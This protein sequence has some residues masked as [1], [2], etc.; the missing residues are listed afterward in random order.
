[1]FTRFHRIQNASGRSYEGS[2]IGLS[3]IKELIQQHGGEI[4]VD[5]NEGKGSTFTV[6]VPFGIK[7]PA[8]I[9][10]W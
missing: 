9:A 6:T 2:G 10:N 7:P 5:S 3:M 4:T 1:M 8:R